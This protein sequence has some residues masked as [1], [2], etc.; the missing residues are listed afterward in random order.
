MKRMPNH[1]VGLRRA[2]VAV[3]ALQLAV[4][5]L[6]AVADG[7]VRTLGST[8]EAHVDGFGSTHE[9]RAHP[10]EC[11]A[12]MALRPCYEAPGPVQPS[13]SLFTSLPAPD[14][15]ITVASSGAGQAL[16]AR[17]PPVRIG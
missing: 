5:P 14:F 17:S 7:L 16:R 13:C 2:I 15:G 8:L 6:A 12:C 10:H 11:A 9:T 3:A 1:S 4:A